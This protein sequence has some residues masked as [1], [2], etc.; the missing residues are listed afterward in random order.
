MKEKDLENDLR[1]IIGERIT[2]SRFER[3]FYTSDLMPIPKMIKVP[4]DAFHST[5]FKA[6][7]Y[8]ITPK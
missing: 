8:G 7:S 4:F 6:R 1:K 2:T 5:E 3:W